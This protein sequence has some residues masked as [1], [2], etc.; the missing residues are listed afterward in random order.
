M[1]LQEAPHR[2]LDMLQ[3]AEEQQA[4]V[5]HGMAEQAEAKAA[6]A[7]AVAAAAARQPAP[8]LSRKTQDKAGSILSRFR[9]DPSGCIKDAKKLLNE[10]AQ[11]VGASLHV[12]ETHDAGGGIW[13]G[14]LQ[15]VRPGEAPLCCAGIGQGKQGA[16]HAAAGHL[17]AQLASAS[18]PQ[19]T[20]GAQQQ[21]ASSAQVKVRLLN[22]HAAACM[23]PQRACDHVQP[24]RRARRPC[25]QGA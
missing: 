22:V 4:R 21:D 15:F 24:V 23:L 20:G 2:S 1:C 8:V 6:E 19:G 14:E 7:A 9:E 5:I 17:L 3:N 12:G 18:L 13:H 10:Y 16:L 25:T 11:V